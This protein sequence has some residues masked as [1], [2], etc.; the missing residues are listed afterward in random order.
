MKIVYGVT[1]REDKSYW[2]RIGIAFT[3]K[4]GSLN[5]KLDFFPTDILNT[6]IQVRDQADRDDLPR[7][8]VPKMKNGDRHGVVKPS[9]KDAPIK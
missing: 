5:L 4:D 3:N 6:T 8:P 2:T 1:E 7:N 9:E